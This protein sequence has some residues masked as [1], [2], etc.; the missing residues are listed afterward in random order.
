[1]EKLYYIYKITLLC[2]HFKNMYYYGKHSTE[3]IEDNYAG[4]GS[5]LS[6]YYK[7]Y[8]KIHG[9]T[10][11]KE[12][13]GFFTNEKD[14]DKAEALYIADKPKNDPLCLN[15]KREYIKPQLKEIDTEDFDTIKK[16]FYGVYD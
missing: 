16:L 1:M 2:G 3:N 8:G 13:L 15:K 12:I 9:V 5:T 6:K 4:S 11:K 10:Y 14:L 7:L